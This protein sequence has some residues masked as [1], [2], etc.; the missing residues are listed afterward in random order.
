MTFAF[1][2]PF[3]RGVGHLETYPG[4]FPLG[5]QPKPLERRVL[6][7]TADDQALFGC[8]TGRLNGQGR[9]AEQVETRHP[10]L[11]H[12]WEARMPK[13][14]DEQKVSRPTGKSFA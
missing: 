13:A 8:P 12:A 10:R 6:C 1:H 9:F 7:Q 3:E 4:W 5:F 2:L 14:L 11:S